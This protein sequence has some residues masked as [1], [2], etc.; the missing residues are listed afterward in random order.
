[1]TDPANS[2]ARAPLDIS[3]SA[4]LVVGLLNANQRVEAMRLLERQ[5]EGQ[6]DI[7]QDALDRMVSYRGRDAL[8]RMEADVIRSMDPVSDP[9]AA[10]VYTNLGRLGLAAGQ[11]R[12]PTEADVATLTDTQ[13]YDVYASIIETRGNDAARESLRNGDRIV[14]GLRQENSTVDSATRDQPNAVA[15]DDP[16]TPADESR[17][18]TGVY[19]DRVVVL[20][21]RTP[22]GG[23]APE[24]W[25]F[26][27]ANTEPSAQYDHHAQGRDRQEPYTHVQRRRA[28]GED[29][30]GDGVRDLGRLREGT[31]EM[32]ATTHPRPG[33]GR[34]DF[35]L[36]PTPEAVAANPL[37]VQRD[38]NADGRFDHNDTNGLQPLNN[39]FKIHRGSQGNT[40]SAG[41][42]T[43][44]GA[45]YDDFVA[46]VRGNP[47]QTRWQYVLTETVPG[48][49]PVQGQQQG[50]PPAQQ[51]RPQD[52]PQPPPNDARPGRELA[53]PEPADRRATLPQDSLM[54]RIEQTLDRSGAA[55]NLGAQERENVLAAS[56]NALSRLPRVDHIGLYNGNVVGTYAPNGLGTEPMHNNAVNVQQARDT[57]AAQ[58]LAAY[59]QDQQ[60]RQFAAQQVEEPRSHGARAA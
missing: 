27:N 28:E 40:D 11:P 53:P 12:F 54:Q 23:G 14:L 20:G 32:L 1:M 38:T 58:S 57:P 50:L 52:A 9:D 42:Q 45:E 56:Y 2:E 30:N 4:D 59:T 19:D 31:V 36:R 51:S 46:A 13:R 43:I 37:G 8:G 5:R 25:Q 17:R 34:D 48:Q 21:R 6:P 16:A 39:T 26:G 33:G 35:S 47:G 3:A 15:V 10:M 7:V 24:V 49:A 55:Q 29:V 60:Q 18:G 22:E 41:C 44:R